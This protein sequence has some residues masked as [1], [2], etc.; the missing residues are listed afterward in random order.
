MCHKGM[1]EVG[2]YIEWG[3]LHMG[4]VYYMLTF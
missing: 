2:V 3:G 4:S 1:G